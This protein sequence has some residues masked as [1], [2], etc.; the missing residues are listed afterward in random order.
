[1]LCASFVPHR[2]PFVMPSPVS[3]GLRAFFRITCFCLSFR[4]ISAQPATGP[5]SDPTYQ[6]L[7]NITLSGESIG[8]SN[9]TLKRD[10]GTFHLR[11][12]TMCFVNPV[13]GKVTG[14]VF[15]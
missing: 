3:R 9:L 4:H 1:M 8:V 5:N 6:Q 12:G 7:R 13:Q 14:A 11:S 15:V 2:S 10:A